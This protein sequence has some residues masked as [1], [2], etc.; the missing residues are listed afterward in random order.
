MTDK[1][2]PE[3][4]IQIADVIR[5]ILEMKFSLGSIMN[6]SA[7]A[8]ACAYAVAAGID[9][10]FVECGVWRGGQ[11][12]VAARMLESAGSSKQIWLYDTF[13]GMTAPTAH[14]VDFRGR[15]ASDKT[16]SRSRAIENDWVYADLPE[17][18]SNLQEFGVSTEP[19]VFVVGD[20]QETLSNLNSVPESISV[21][22]LDTDW[23]ES[24]KKE[25]EVLYPRL[26]SG[27]ILIIDDYGH[28]GG[29]QKAVDEYFGESLP[30]LVPLDYTARVCVKP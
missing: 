26:S 30:F 5:K 7:T 18:K 2:P 23:Y 4:P 11:S 15:P 16:G 17:V 21:L 13:S 8:R 19:I 27:G 25:L 28:W 1:I 22:R 29:A 24:T 14:D 12:I 3:I 6:L 9:G 20:V 10:D